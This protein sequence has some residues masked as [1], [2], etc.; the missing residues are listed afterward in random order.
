MVPPKGQ[1]VLGEEWGWGMCRD[2]LRDVILRERTKTQFPHFSLEYRM[3]LSSYFEFINFALLHLNNW[4]FI[5][6]TALSLTVQSQSLSSF[7]RI[8]MKLSMYTLFEPVRWY[9]LFFHYVFRVCSFTDTLSIKGQFLPNKTNK[10]LFN[11]LDNAIDTELLCSALICLFAVHRY[12]CYRFYSP[13]QNTT[14]LI[15]PCIVICLLHG[16]PPSPTR[17]ER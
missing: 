14:D 13:V 5:Y 11:S 7:K 9:R 4:R 16:C 17:L 10:T 6:E 8:L 12:K 15:M 1:R 2:D 3:F